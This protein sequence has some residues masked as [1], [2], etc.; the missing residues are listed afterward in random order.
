VSGAM[1]VISLVCL[2]MAS[3]VLYVGTYNLFIFLKHRKTSTNLPFAL[4]CFSVAM[5]D[6]FC[7]GLY[8]AHSLEQGIFWQRLQLLTINFISLFIVWFVSRYT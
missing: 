1:Q 8:S 3:V 4:A 6:L 2:M 5:Y 7:I